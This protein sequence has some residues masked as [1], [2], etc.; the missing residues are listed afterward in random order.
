MPSRRLTRTLQAVHR[1]RSEAAV[2][3]RSKLFAATY[4]RQMRKVERAGLRALRQRVLSAAN[5]RVLEIG[6]GTGANLS[7]YGPDVESLALTEPEPPMVRRL[8]RRARAD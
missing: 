2:T 5:G 3:L 7:F 8:Q 6:A 1:Q 4:D